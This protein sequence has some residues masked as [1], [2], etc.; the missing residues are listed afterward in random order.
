M[1]KII[2]LGLLAGLA[3]CKET[4]TGLEKSVFNTS[5]EK[6]VDY[7]TGSLKSPSSLKISESNISTNIARAEDI[8]TV[9][10]DLIIKDGVVKDNIRAEK[11]RFRELTVDI[12]YE[13]QNSYGASLRGLYQCKYLYMLNR[14]EISPKPLNTY[15]YKLISD[16]EDIN[17]GIHIPIANFSGSNFYLNNTIKNIIGTKDSNFNALDEENYQKVEDQY[18]LIHRQK[19]A[20]RL[21][22]S[23]S[24][25]IASDVEA[26]AR[27]A[28]EEVANF[29]EP[30]HN[31]IE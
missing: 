13:A 31:P 4:S 11:A 12:D 26:S 9:F 19:E 2:L 20:D 10:G 5:Y 25:S 7:L 16:G 29:M 22:K 23:W 18:E 6:C 21:K 8:S 1:K 24:S 3:G 27:A 28:A 17:L 30:N 15:L 14:D